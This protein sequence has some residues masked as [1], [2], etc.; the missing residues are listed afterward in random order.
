MGH[1]KTA[2][3]LTAA[4]A[5]SAAIKAMPAIRRDTIQPNVYKHACFEVG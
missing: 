1:F 3:V 2:R 5:A 4:T